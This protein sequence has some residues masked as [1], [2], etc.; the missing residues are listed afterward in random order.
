[1]KSS[2]KSVFKILAF[3][4]LLVSILL[5]FNNVFKLKY[6]DGILQMTSFYEQEE[7]TVDVL[8]L[9]SSHAFV[10]FNNGTLWDEYGMASYNLGGSGQPMWN[11][12]FYLKEAL[13]TQH[14]ELIVLEG[15]GLK[16]DFEYMDEGG[17]IKNTYGMKWS[18]DKIQAIK[19]SSEPEQNLQLLLDYTQYH[20]RYSTLGESDFVR[21][22]TMTATEGVKYF[23]G[24]KGQYLFRYANPVEIADVSNVTEKIALHPK[25]EEY[26]RKILELANSEGIPVA[27]IIAPYSLT[28]YEQSK[29]L[30]AEEISKEYNAVKFINGN[31]I[32]D[33]F[34]LDLQADYYDRGHMNVLGSEKF[35][36]YIGAYLKEHFEISDR[37]NNPQYLSWEE[38]AAYTRQYSANMKL[39]LS[40]DI[41]EILNYLSDPNYSIFIET[42]GTC[43][44][45]DKDLCFV[46]EALGLP[47]NGERGIWLK[48]VD[49]IVWY[50]GAGEGEHYIRTRAHDFCMKRTL[51][52]SRRFYTNLIM[53]DDTI[54][55]IVENGVNIVVYD[56]VTETVADTFGINASGN[57]D[58][59]R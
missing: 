49:G 41:N 1:M 22:K 9:G 46:F 15:F 40:K 36:K 56:N 14:P 17:I 53:I 19:V 16:I 51:D 43:T 30:R 47:T 25:T 50:S 13:K 4:L 2:L 37:R 26:Y 3:I 42:S 18:S 59:V 6:S 21:N 7:N 54:Y 5:Y 55:G 38:N 39:S 48:T 52:E 57:C 10:N 20:D 23:Q 34:G 12:Y 33:R 11:S 8:I 45:T 58:I 35:S 27:V 29:Y 31:M 24:W 28:E 32:L 44:T